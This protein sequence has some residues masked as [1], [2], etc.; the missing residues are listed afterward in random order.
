MSI[1]IALA[2]IV[3]CGSNGSSDITT[4]D[5]RYCY[6]FNAPDQP[7][8][9]QYDVA[10]ATYCSGTIGHVAGPK[11]TFS[12]YPLV[13]DSK[14]SDAK[15]ATL[16]V[17]DT[18]TSRAISQVSEYDYVLTCGDAVNSKSVTSRVRVFWSTKQ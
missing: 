7:F 13:L 3:P 16:T 14:G 9:V 12:L 6:K 4:G 18:P 11:R 15:S 8:V 17:E 2:E 5:P 10:N 1:E